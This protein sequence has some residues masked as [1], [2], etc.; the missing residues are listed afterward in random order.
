MGGIA[1]PY[2]V[3]LHVRRTIRRVVSLSCL[4]LL[5]SASAAFAACPAPSVSTPFSQWADTNNYFLAPGGSMEGTPAQVGW[6][7]TNATLT[8]GNEPFNVNDS[9]DNQSLTIDGGGSATS[10]YFCVDNTMSALRF[11]AQ[12]ATAGSD[13]Q[14]DA[15]V[16]TRRGVATVSV[17]S[18]A[19]GSMSSWAPTD[20]ITGASASL[21][22]NQTV[23]V[24]L[25]FSVPSTDGSW[26]LDDVYVDPYRSG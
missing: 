13:L 8:Q 7:L 16:Q 21:P 2:F 1:L 18:L 26:Q 4:A 12:Q 10:P 19:D 22:D 3:H 14:I 23:M 5:A 9:A 20:M 25:R 6:S 17:G 15:L 11:F 24:A